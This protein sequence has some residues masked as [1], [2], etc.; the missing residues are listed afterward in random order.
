LSGE[1]ARLNTLNGKV[2]EDSLFPKTDSGLDVETSIL[3]FVSSLRT[4]VSEISAE[5]ESEITTFL[6]NSCDKV[7]DC[8]TDFLLAACPGKEVRTA[9]HQ[10][11]KK[12]FQHYIDSDTSTIEGV[13]WVRLLPKHKSKQQSNRIRRAPQW[14]K[15]VPDY[16]KF[17]M[18][19]ENID[20]MTALNY[21]TKTLRIKQDALRFAGTKDKRAVTCQWITA[22]RLKP[23]IF[24][25]FNNMKYPPFIR[26]GDFSYG[27][28]QSFLITQ[29]V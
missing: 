7:E 1:V 9:L 19:K 12:Y 24:N 23:T 2:L 15:D 29:L 18:L 8:P 28:S 6:H 5:R 10:L 16:L 13:Q 11:I 25:R 20:T 4:T 14:P 17:K 26:F 3:E 21:V 27:W 22:F